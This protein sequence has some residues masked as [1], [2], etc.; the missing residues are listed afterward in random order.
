MEDKVFSRTLNIAH[1][2]ARSLAPENTMAAAKKAHEIGADMWE[3]DVCMTSDGELILL[4]DDTLVRTSNA[5]EVFPSRSP[6]RVCDF[7]FE[8]IRR[9]DFGSWF[10]IIDPFGQINYGHVTLPERLKF[11]DEPAP[12]L[13]EALEFTKHHDWKVNVE[14]KDLTGTNGHALVAEKVVKLIR[15]F[16]IHED[17]IISSFQHDYI[18]QVKLLD[19]LINLAV[20]VEEEVPDPIGLVK[21][22]G[23]QAYN[24]KSGAISPDRITQLREQGIDVYVY[25]V[26]DPAEMAQLVR[27]QASG[28]FT[29]YPQILKN[30][31]ASFG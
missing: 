13:R 26:N 22:L 18:K 11:S 28:I 29:D 9:L 23:A 10:N 24:P 17:V 16:G 5:A 4:H 2:G 12:T 6:W 21:S 7:T 3:L 19:P 15:D 31:L 1:R 30:V 20:L 14:I 25:T 27:A 8:E